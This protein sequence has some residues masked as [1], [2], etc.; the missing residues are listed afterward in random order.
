MQHPRCAP[1]SRFREEVKLVWRKWLRRR[2]RGDR[3]AWTWLNHV[4]A[5]YPLPPPGLSGRLLA[6][7][8]RQI[9]AP[10]FRLKHLFPVL[11]LRCQ[12]SDPGLMLRLQLSFLASFLCGGFLGNLCGE[13]NGNIIANAKV[14]SMSNNL[15]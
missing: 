6:F 10:Q 3:G 15:A 11:L 13:A 2:K 4:L 9:E 8:N 14:Q 7:V 1:L 12:R 5:R